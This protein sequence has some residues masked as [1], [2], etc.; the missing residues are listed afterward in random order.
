MWILERLLCWL[1]G[2]DEA[3]EVEPS[4]AEIIEVDFGAGPVRVDLDK[5]DEIQ[6]TESKNDGNNDRRKTADL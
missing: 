1:F 2:F 6:F 4:K 3:K 5:Y